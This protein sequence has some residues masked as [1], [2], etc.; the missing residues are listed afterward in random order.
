M[1]KAFAS[2]ILPGDSVTVTTGN[3]YSAPFN[4][5]S[6]PSNQSVSYSLGVSTSA[7][8]S[9]NDINVTNDYGYQNIRLIP[10]G[11]SE[12]A[13]L[14][15]NVKIYPNPAPGEVSI[16]SDIKIG[17]IEIFDLTGRLTRNV[18]VNQFQFH[19]GNYKLPKGLYIF[20][21][22]TEKGFITRKVL[23]E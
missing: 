14:T 21:V 22:N 3:F 4:L 11:L 7:P 9:M 17:S 8:D 23:I 12:S 19:L 5:S 1:N 2:T 20:K 15:S 16:S 13:G 6:I 10:V 18:D